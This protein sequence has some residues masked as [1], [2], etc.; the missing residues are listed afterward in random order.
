MREI[1]FRAWLENKML[2]HEDLVD[3]DQEFYAMYTIL[4]E[5]Q[6]DM[7]FMQYTGLKDKNGKEIF[8]GDIVRIYSGRIKGS[9]KFQNAM[10]DVIEEGGN[11]S[12]LA[13]HDEDI[14][15]IGNI[16]ENPELLE[17]AK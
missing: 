5:P 14:E 12:Y 16:H 9:V 13:E 8:E 4:T 2:S 6:E 17:K 3:M 11:T 1:K 7:V 15:I 10:F